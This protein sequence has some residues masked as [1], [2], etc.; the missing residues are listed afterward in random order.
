MSQTTPGLT[1]FLDWYDIWAGLAGVNEN[2]ETWL[3]DPPVGVHLSVQPA[4]RSQIFLRAEKPWEQGG[5]HYPL[6][7]QEEGRYRLWYWSTGAAKGAFRLH[8][9]AESEDGFH[10]QRPELGLVEYEGSKANNLVFRYED[11]ELNSVFIDPNADPEERY[12]AISPRT[13]FFRDGVIDPDIGWTEFRELAAQTNA[14]TDPTK[15]TMDAVKEKFNVWRDNVVMGAVSADGLRWRILD[16]PLVNVGGTPLDTHNIAAYE[17]ETGEYVAYLRGFPEELQ[18]NFRGRRA[19]RKVA[20]K[21]FGNWSA[22][23]YVLMADPQDR[24]DDDIYTSAYCRYP[25]VQGLHL[26]FPAVYHRLDSELDVQLAVSRDGW[27]WSRPARKPVIGRDAEDGEYGMVTAGPNLVPLNE[28]EWGLP[29][30]C[31]YMRHDRAP[32]EEGPCRDVFRWAIWERD[33]LVALEAPL[34]GQVTTIGRLCCGDQLRLNFKTLR[35]GWIKAEI[36][37]PPT[38]PISPVEAIEGFSL[39]E[40]D[41]LSGDELDQVATWNGKSDLSRL[42]G[43]KVAVRFHM[44]RAKL[45]SFAI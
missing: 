35:A 13:I 7:L 19:V 30:A 2:G 29:Y 42:R 44:A 28:R 6:I 20:G 3:Q 43:R 41:A 34:E 33:R 31:T 27:N 38:E 39:A 11:F 12:K 40:A 23:R 1:P 26:M 36:V 45:F 21:Q 25:G 16:E 32:K 15:N 18:H 9:Y 5:L 22:P 17:P 14:A 37:T 4:R 8:G 24:C 10:W